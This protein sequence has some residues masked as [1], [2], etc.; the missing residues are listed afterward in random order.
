MVREQVQLTTSAKYLSEIPDDFFAEIDRVI[1]K[2]TCKFRGPTARTILEK[3][4]QN[5][6]LTLP[7]FKTYF[8]VSTNKIV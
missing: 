1:L 5:G 8:K 2:F 6:E 3:K 4:N 7:S